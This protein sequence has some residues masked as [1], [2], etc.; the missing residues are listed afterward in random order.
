MI[1]A[2]SM[3]HP[4]TKLQPP[5]ESLKSVLPHAWVR[6]PKS[7]CTRAPQPGVADAL[8]RSFQLRPANPCNTRACSMQHPCSP[9]ASCTVVH[10]GN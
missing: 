4:C 3:Q 9:S 8:A 2:C 6:E 5:V 1:H 10:R 7:D